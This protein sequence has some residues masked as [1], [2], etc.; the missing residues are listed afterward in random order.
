[1]LSDRS[2]QNVQIS[3]GSTLNT[4]EVL[5]D[6]GLLF[7]LKDSARNP[8]KSKDIVNQ[9]VLGDD[10]NLQV[11]R[12]RSNGEILENKNA[13]GRAFHT[14][15]NLTFSERERWRLNDLELSIFSH[16]L[17]KSTGLLQWMNM[18]IHSSF[19]AQNAFKVP[20]SVME[21]CP[22]RCVARCEIKFPEGNTL[23]VFG[24]SSSISLSTWPGGRKCF[25]DPWGCFRS[26]TQLGEER[27]RKYV[28]IKEDGRQQA[29]R[30]TKSRQRYNMLKNDDKTACFYH[31]DE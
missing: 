9:V 31:L 27:E 29:G 25:R 6:Q 7:S 14:F 2:K 20:Q 24:N 19:L 10:C 28:R 23:E 5:W 11:E 4:A 18:L 17:L 13:D 16:S 1:M 3:E 12:A 21:M 15:P 8:H 26:K 30:C 22:V